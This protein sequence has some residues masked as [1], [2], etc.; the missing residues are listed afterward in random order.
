VRNTTRT[1]VHGGAR[2]QNTNVNIHRDID[3]DVDRNYHPVAR[4]VGVAAAATVTA[5]VIGSIVYSVPASCTTIVSHG[6]SYRQCGSTWYQ[7]RYSGTQVSYVVV[8]PP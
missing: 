6:I 7:P 2:I 8:A 1:S 3:V 5:A 4:A